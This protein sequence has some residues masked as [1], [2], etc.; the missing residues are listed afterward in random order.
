LQSVRTLSKWNNTEEGAEG[1]RGK[2]LCRK[3]LKTSVLAMWQPLLIREGGKKELF[4][5]SS[6]YIIFYSSGSYII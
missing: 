5:L 1:R 3:R 4:L 2:R 6:Y